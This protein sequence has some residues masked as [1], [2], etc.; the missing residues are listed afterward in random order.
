MVLAFLNATVCGAVLRVCQ[1]RGARLWLLA[2]AVLASAPTLA[3]DTRLLAGLEARNIGPAAMSGR[4]SALDALA[5]DPNFI[6]A[7]AGTGGVWISENGGLNW[8][9]VF[10]D[11]PVTSIGALAINQ[12]N[13]NIIWVGT[14]E[15]NVRNSTSIGAGI[16]KSVDGGETWVQMG[17]EDSERIDRIALHPDNPDVAYVAALGTLWGPNES[18]GV[19]RTIDGGKTWDKILYVDERTG[20]TDVKLDPANPH[21]LYAAMWEFRRWP[22]QFKSGGPGSGLYVSHDGGDSWQQRTAADGLPKGELGRMVV[23]PSPADSSR[24][25]VL[26]EAKK[27][28]LMRSD[29]GGR[30][31]KT[32]NDDYNV[33]IRP[34][35]YTELFADPQNPDRV[36]NVES[37]L[38]VSVDGGKSFTYNEAVDCCRPGNFVHIDNH[39]F[40]INP[41]NPENILLGNDGGIAVTRDR[42][43]TWRFVENLAL[44]QFYHIAVDNDD[45]YNVY[46]GLQDNGSWRGPAEVRENAG[47]RNL[48]WQ[49]VGFG[50]GFDTQPDPRNSRR[51]FSM[52]QGGTLYR[53]S[54]DSGEQQLIRPAPPTPDTELRFNWNAALAIDPFNPDVVYYGSQFVH[55]SVDF[56]ASWEVISP[57]LTTN[58]PAFQTYRESGG[59]TP[60]V[61]AAENFTTIVAIAPSP[62]TEGVL[63]VGTDDGRVHVTRDG[64]ASWTRVDTNVRGVPAGAWVPMIEPS[65]HDAAVAFVVFDD[66]RRSDMKTYVAR[67]ENYGARWRL[68]SRDDNLEGYALSIK[69]DPIDPELLFLGTEFGLYFSSTGGA[70][71]HRFSAGVPTVSVMDMAIQARENDLVLGTHG[72][73]VYVID[74]YSAL[75]GLDDGT[76][77]QRFALLSAGPGQQY[78]RAQTPGGR[79]TGSGEFRAPNEPYGALL[80]FVVAGDDLPHPDQDAER[81]RLNAESRAKAEASGDEEG[82]SDTGEGDDKPT[83]VELRV[84][85]DD[86]K[87]LR[88]RR[89]KVHQG[90]NRITWDLRADGV[91]PLP[92]PEPAKLEDGLPR[93][94]QVPPGTYDVVLTFDGIE[95]R[96]SVEVLADAHADYSLAGREANYAAQLSLQELRERLVT[97]TEKV[98]H[99][100]DDVKVIQA[101]IKRAQRAEED[102]HESL[103][104][105][106]DSVLEALNDWEKRV[107][108]PAKTRGIVFDDDKLT[109]VLG[110]AQFYVGSTLG[111]PSSTARIHMERA[112]TAV[113]A[114]EADYAEFVR[115]TL[116]PFA[117]TAGQTPLGLFSG[118]AR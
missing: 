47:I 56:G 109:S 101:R 64:G 24:V 29:D 74:D 44:A 113:G 5:S 95:Q 34:F 114:A 72:R 77:A 22:Y 28:A 49:E 40:W 80:T 31:F 112:A 33:A 108:V 21:K 11:Q 96:A 39:A 110:I 4:I 19:Y 111:E 73:S 58:N 15:S 54:L 35:Y 43:E 51:G 79:F 25:Y 89:F 41:S 94:P 115:E 102:V 10:D 103:L 14:G 97:L 76:M 12:K 27:S 7:G 106:A 16:F 23:A 32:V 36:Y 104:E 45:P 50:D 8:R 37:R 46:G 81:E 68:L 6:V 9:P 13:P 17:L 52:S 90:I 38:R 92:G 93:G 55:K 70:N 26:V 75:R 1:G 91:R 2:T 82:D 20:A 118:G 100:R 87:L 69:Q 63:W 57:D 66:H 30:T 62:V 99:A 71:W 61:T 42:G 105:T 83:K 65:P 86:G 67:A 88:T 53:W 116:E 60:D 48:H 117:S 85:A 98:V 3:L 59:L 107:R 18:R 78:V 84:F